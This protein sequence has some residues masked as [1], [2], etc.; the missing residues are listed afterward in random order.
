MQ[1]HSPDRLACALA[2][3]D[4][5]NQADP[6]LADWQ[7]QPQAQEW[8]YSQHMT[9]WLFVLEPAPNALLQ[10]ACRAQHLERWSLPRSSYPDGRAA[11]YEWRQACGQMHG[12][13]A[14]EIMAGCGYSAADCE[15]VAAIIGKCDLAHDAAT[16]ALEDVA[17]LVFLE[18]YFAD[19]YAQKPDYDAAQWLRIVRRTWD[20]MTPR[21]HAAALQLAGQL[22]AHLLALVQEAIA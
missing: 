6:R 15:R 13:R 14:A 21:G 18:R 1:A 10:I 3:I 8:I 16:Q 19:F 11:Y 5:A 7:G 20:K 22:P 9:R 17:C 12:A 4:A 2:Q